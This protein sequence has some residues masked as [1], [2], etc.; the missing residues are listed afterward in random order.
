MAAAESGLGFA[1]L[2]SRGRLPPHEPKSIRE[3][4]Q[5]LETQGGAR[6]DCDVKTSERSVGAFDPAMR[7]SILPATIDVADGWGFADWR[8]VTA[9]QQS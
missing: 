2:D 9:R 7:A 5:A 4:D 1:Q 3:L 6:V 8:V